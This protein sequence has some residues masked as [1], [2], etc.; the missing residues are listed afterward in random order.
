MWEWNYFEVLLAVCAT[1]LTNAVFFDMGGLNTWFLNM[2]CF[3][4]QSC[5]IQINKSFIQRAEQM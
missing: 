2:L 3:L 5:V 4:P 1:K